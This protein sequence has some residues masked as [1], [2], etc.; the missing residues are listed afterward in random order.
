MNLQNAD[1]VLARSTES[2]KYTTPDTIVSLAA[3]DANDL[4]VVGGST[5]DGQG[6]IHCLGHDGEMRWTQTYPKHVAVVGV[7]ARGNLVGM[8]SESKSMYMFTPFGQ[9]VWQDDCR[10]EPKSIAISANGRFTVAG[11]ADGNINVYDG[12]I[13]AARKFAWKHRFGRPNL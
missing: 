7:A 12:D 5:K 1:T 6:V 8:G 11:L 4:I 13:V 10:S 2:R 9:L 3:S